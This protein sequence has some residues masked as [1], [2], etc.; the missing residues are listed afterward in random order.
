METLKNVF[1]TYW[2]ET[3]THYTT[4]SWTTIAI[5]VAILALLIVL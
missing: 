5:D 3:K 2:T 1:K 4:A